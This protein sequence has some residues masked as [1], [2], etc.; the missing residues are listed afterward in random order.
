MINE[1]RHHEKVLNYYKKSRLFYDTLLWGT[2][3]FGYYPNAKKDISEKKA[4]ILMQDLMAKELDI[5]ENQLLLDAGCGQGIVSVYFSG[6]YGCKIIG[7]DIVPF[8]IEKANRLAK[9][10]GIENRVEYH[11][12]DY[13]T[14]TFDNNQ[15]DAVYTMESFMHSPDTQKTL[16]EFYRILKPGG[17]L[18]MFEFTIASNAAFTAW[19][20][21]I[22][23]IVIEGAALASL[24]NMKH[25]TFGEIL[26][27][28]DFVSVE[29][30]NITQHMEPSFY[31]HYRL[32][33]IPYWFVKLFS[34][35]ERFI[36][37]T[38]AY[39]IYKMGKKDLFRYCTFVAS[40]PSK[41]KSN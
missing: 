33:R 20:K 3:H 16:R 6:K 15:F 9:K 2:I 40:K 23:D 26:K 12:M 31:R 24:K 22:A 7:I 34:L 11:I 25:D 21:K 37:I 19:E 29:E 4:Q 1:N 17:K 41:I 36:N 28:T 30:K 32:F 35:Q 13:S 39:E 38:T 14:T 5:K 18:V 8:V 10:L 27:A